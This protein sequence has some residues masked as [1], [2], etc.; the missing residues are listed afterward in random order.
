MGIF[1][2]WRWLAGMT[3]NTK[4]SADQAASNRELVK[5]IEGLTKVVT[6]GEN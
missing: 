3:E 4:A 6:D 1:F 2:G 5:A